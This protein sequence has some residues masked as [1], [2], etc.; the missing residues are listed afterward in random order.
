L[1][2]HARRGHPPAAG[3][4]NALTQEGNIVKG[5]CNT[6]EGADAGRPPAS[7]RPHP[8]GGR[9]NGRPFGLARL[10]VAA[11]ALLAIAGT[12]LVGRASDCP[13]SIS[14]TFANNGITWTLTFNSCT[15][16]AGDTTVCYTLSR[17]G[18]DTNAQISHF[19]IGLCAELQGALQSVS[20]PNGPAS[21]DI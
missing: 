18:G 8:P 11:L 1:L 21:F 6:G 12:A 16:A 13:T 17:M 3:A 2:L 7:A 15:H 19:N 10:F 14:H 20:G 9:G 4:C 5:F